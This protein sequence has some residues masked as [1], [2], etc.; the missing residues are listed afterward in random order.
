[1]TF[2]CGLDAEDKYPQKIPNPPVSIKKL[3]WSFVIY[4]LLLHY[5]HI[6]V[7]IVK[8]LLDCISSLS[9]FPVLRRQKW[10]GRPGGMGGDAD[11]SLYTQPRT[12]IISVRDGAHSRSLQ[13]SRHQAFFVTLSTEGRARSC[14]WVM[15][16]VQVPSTSSKDGMILM[17][18]KAHSNRCKTCTMC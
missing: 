17:L 1:M 10:G 6:A 3:Y 13:C 2:C 16:W 5:H 7:C 18:S 12:C 4:L 8:F 9:V 15:M 11:L 14:V